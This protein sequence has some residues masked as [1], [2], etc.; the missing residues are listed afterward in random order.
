M[1]RSKHDLRLDRGHHLC[2]FLQPLDRL[3][4]GDLGNKGGFTLASAQRNIPFQVS[5]ALDVISVVAY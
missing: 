1:Q 4:S 5:G 3:G 2:I